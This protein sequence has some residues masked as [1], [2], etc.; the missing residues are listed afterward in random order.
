MSPDGSLSPDG[1]GPGMG[2]GMEDWP[3]PSSLP[4]HPIPALGICNTSL[5]TSFV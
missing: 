2:P 3:S 1:L 4:P 5:T